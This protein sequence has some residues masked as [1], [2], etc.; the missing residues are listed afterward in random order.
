MVNQKLKERFLKYISFDT[1]SND[2]SSTIPST[3]KQKDLGSYL[4]SELKSIGVVE[5]F[6]DEHGYVYGYIPSNCNSTK[7]IGLIAHID[8]SDEASGENVKPQI[9]SNYDGNVIVLNKELNLEL[10]PNEFNYLNNQVG[11]ELITTDGTTLLGADDKAGIAIIMTVVEEL[12]N[13]S[14]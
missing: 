5:S 11:H 10:D 1:Q 7:T 8:T 6:M 12:L 4:A 13:I 14:P 3:L 2:Q 9:I